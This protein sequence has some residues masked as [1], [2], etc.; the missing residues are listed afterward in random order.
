MKKHQIIILVIGAV[1]LGGFVLGAYIP[2]SIKKKS[3]RSKRQTAEHVIK[4]LRGEVL[5]IPAL[6]LEAES[7]QKD[8]KNYRS[9]IP[10]KMDLGQFLSTIA[11]IMNE[12]NLNDQ[13][14]K[15]GSD[16][17]IG[18]LGC[19]PVDIKCSGR[20]VNLFEFFK[21]LQNLDR[22]VRVVLVNIVNDNALTGELTME[23][24]AVIYYKAQKMKG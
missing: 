1:M 17:L 10:E 3:V 4:K 5:Q 22:A 23:T 8:E 24:R 15:P 12:N 11:A 20:L 6:K 13:S 9:G 18:K 2:L 19:I 21:S 7:L 14:V 16:M